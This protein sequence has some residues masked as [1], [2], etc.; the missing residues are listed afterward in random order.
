M[1]G[2]TFNIAMKDDWKPP[3][4]AMLIL[5][6]NVTKHVGECSCNIL[7]HINS[8]SNGKL[9]KVNLVKR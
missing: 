9:N 6:S 4:K 3:K 5:L 8:F 1:K 7:G 2:F